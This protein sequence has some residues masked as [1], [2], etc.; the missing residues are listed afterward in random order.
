MP[1]NAVA[2]KTATPSSLDLAADITS[3]CRDLHATVVGDPA[4]VW[5]KMTDGAVAQ[6]PFVD[7]ASITVL[8]DRSTVAGRAGT[9]RHADALDEVAHCYLQGPGIDAAR[10]QEPQHIDDLYGD[11][12]WPT[13]AANAAAT[14]VRS[15]AAYPLYHHEYG[16]AALNLFADT[17]A[18]FA[19]DAGRLAGMFACS[20]SVAIESAQ[21][22]RRM[23]HLLTN[24]DLV[25]QAK[26]LLM[27]RFGIDAVAAFAMLTQL[28]E[29]DRQ[30]LPAVARK[31][32]RR[33]TDPA[34]RR[35]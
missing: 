30:P 17:A 26:G 9:D 35:A 4:A 31:L 12:R 16:C 3:F 25:G 13:F 2:K 24:R 33:S 10:Q 14:P 15:I 21:R 20:A 1:R 29:R 5:Q 7:H 28:A 23:A 6:L 22:E 18:A 27:E 34:V 11:H 8:D 32:L 19:D